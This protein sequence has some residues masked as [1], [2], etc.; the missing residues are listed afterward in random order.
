MPN[1]PEQTKSSGMRSVS[2]GDKW[3][4]PLDDASVEESNESSLAGKS[5]PSGGD[6]QSSSTDQEKSPPDVVDPGSQGV[7]VSVSKDDSSRTYHANGLNARI[8]DDEEERARMR[9][10]RH[11]FDVRLSPGAYL[12]C[13]A[14]WARQNPGTI[15][16]L[17]EPTD[18]EKTLWAEVVSYEH[19]LADLTRP[20]EDRLYDH[21]EL[22]AQAL[23]VVTRED[24]EQRR[25][26]I[27][28]SAYQ[29]AIAAVQAA[30]SLEEAVESLR[31]LLEDLKDLNAPNGGEDD[32]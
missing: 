3:H 14:Y 17:H 7:G 31:G 26:E 24:F 25:R 1:E 22:Q 8:G 16:L 20:P 15:G 2:A 19:V 5:Q 29:Q 27:K 21:T 9:R 28:S 12:R 23:R 6:N 13:C 32:A 18:R 4:R 11:P 30:S 10:A